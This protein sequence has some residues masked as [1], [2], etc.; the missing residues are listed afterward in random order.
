MPADAVS[1]NIHATAHAATKYDIL[2]SATPVISKSQELQNKLC[3]P[4]ISSAHIR[5]EPDILRVLEPQ[6]RHALQ[7]RLVH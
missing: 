4:Q 5:I 2:P 6:R 7:V 3:E 1:M